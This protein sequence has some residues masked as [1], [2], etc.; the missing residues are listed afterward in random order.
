MKPVNTKKKVQIWHM[1]SWS[2]RED[3]G[4]KEFDTPELAEAHANS[5][6]SK[7]TAKSVPEF[8]IYAELV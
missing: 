3:G 8:Y 7:N 1:D 4:I 5:I 2:G 6:N